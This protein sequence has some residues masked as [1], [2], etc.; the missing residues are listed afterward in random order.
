VSEYASAV[1]AAA[2]RSLTRAPEAK[3]MLIAPMIMVI[4][5]GGLVLGQAGSPPDQV[6]PLIAI[7]SATMIAL[8]SVQLVGN[9]FGYDRAGFRAYVLCPTPRREILIGKNL[10]VAPLIFGLAVFNVVV[11]GIIYP[12]RIDHYPAALA[13]VISMYLIFCVLANTLSILAPIPMAAGSI[14]PANVKMT[15]ILM[16]MAFLFVFPVA[17]LPVFAP[18]GVELLVEEV[19]GIH[20]L[21]VSLILSFLVLGLVI[22]GYRQM[23][24]WQ[25]D[26]LAAREQKILEVVTSKAE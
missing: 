15:P 26:W 11:V 17:M 1:A 18:V 10:A 22:L 24:S 9:Q 19:G 4:V 3:M 20:W 5:F 7:G 12:M 23:V 6:R 8:M 14:Q 16:Q 21:P 2:F 25:G 13:Q